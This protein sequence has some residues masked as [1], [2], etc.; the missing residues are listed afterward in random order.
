[1]KR[2]FLTVMAVLSMTMTFAEEE[3]TTA[4]SNVEAYDM[5]VNIRKLGETLGLTL[6]QMES[7]SDVHHTFCGEMMV[8]AQAQGDDRKALVDKAVT[9]DL[10]YMNYILTDGQFRKYRLLLQTTLVN[11]GIE[12]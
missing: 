10:K 6:D 11:R 3:K 9:K 1:M 2:L 5:S 4:V 12:L 8:A 7:V